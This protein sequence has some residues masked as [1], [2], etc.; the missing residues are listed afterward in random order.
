MKTIV[1]TFSGSEFEYAPL[2]EFAEDGD[3]I[4]ALACED[5]CDIEIYVD[6]EDIYDLVDDEDFEVAVCEKAP[7][8]HNF[9]PSTKAIR[10]Y[11]NETTYSC[12]L[13]ID[14]EFDA[15]KLVLN[16]HK[17]QFQ[18]GDKVI[19]KYGNR[20]LCGIEYDGVEYELEW[21]GNSE[22]GGSEIIWGVD[23]DEVEDELCERYDDVEQLC[24]NWF[25]V[26]NEDGLCNL[27]SP[28][29]KR[30]NNKWYD[31]CGEDF[32]EE[33]MLPVCV[34]GKWGGVNMEGKVIIKA[35]FDESF[36]FK[37]GKAEVKC[38]GELFFIDN[39]GKRIIEST[40][41]GELPLLGMRVLATGKFANYSRDEIRTVI[42]SNGGKYASSVTGSLD[43]LVCGENVGQV[44][45]D[46][47]NELGVRMV[48]ESE[49]Q[50]II[51][52]IDANMEDVEDDWLD[53]E[54]DIVIE[55]VF[56]SLYPDG[57]AVAEF[58]DDENIVSQVLII[59]EEVTTENGKVYTVEAFSIGDLSD[60]KELSLPKTIKSLDGAFMGTTALC[61]RQCKIELNGNPN[62][63]FEGGIFY[64]G[65]KTVILNAQFASPKGDYEISEG[66]IEVQNNAF[67]MANSM[68][69]ITF[70]STIRMIG[71][72]FDG[73]DSLKTVFIKASKDDVSF[74]EEEGVEI[75]PST[76]KVIWVT[77]R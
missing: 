27:C 16:V 46:K 42:E 73:C 2:D 20:M 49:F 71:A 18:V 4:G 32:D 12:E 58:F 8:I 24:N 28:Y 22:N 17:I 56:Y 76:P 13:E 70:P 52:G 44:K 33:G 65:D 21:D 54:G 69:S 14:E 43:L 75:F 30:L 66:V 3:T 7:V 26:T 9:D 41:T 5:S 50:D 34:D 62:I 74:Y 55:N 37:S 29:G 25:K 38:N 60:V 63:V 6:D 48:S 59:P 77:S 68:E 11:D 40:L 23:P 45:I 47:A 31:E 57:S 67:N 1:L 15:S 64:N 39:S 36:C 53:C 19:K 72:A 61:L 10:L 35:K 51:A